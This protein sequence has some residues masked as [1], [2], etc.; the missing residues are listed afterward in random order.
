MQILLNNETVTFSPH[1]ILQHEGQPV[2]SV[3]LILSGN[4]EGRRSDESEPNSITAGAL[5]G[6]LSLLDGKNSFE[7]YRAT[8]YVNALVLPASLYLT[9]AERYVDEEGFQDLGIRRRWL[10]QT[11][12]FGDGLFYPVLNRIASAMVIEDIEDG[13][14][15]ISDATRFALSV[16]ESGII[17]RFMGDEVIETLRAGDVFNEDQCLF[18]ITPRSHLSSIGSSRIWHIPVTTILAVPNVRWKLY[19]LHRRR[20]RLEADIP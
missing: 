5:L 9:F 14:I 18:G 12:L 3:L 1:E 16:I 6:E 7:T 13:N 17:K 10:R 4:A 15:D 2:N 20:Q 19:E 11:T 8:S